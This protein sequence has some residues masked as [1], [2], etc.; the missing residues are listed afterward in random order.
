MLRER[1][2]VYDNKIILEK[3]KSLER[4]LENGIVKQFTYLYATFEIDAFLPKKLI[5]NCSH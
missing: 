5:F 2:D 3:E 4:N 1:F